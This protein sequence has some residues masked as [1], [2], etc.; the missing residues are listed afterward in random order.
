MHIFLIT[1]SFI[2]DVVQYLLDNAHAN[3]LIFL[4][5]FPVGPRRGRP[6]S[7]PCTI[8]P[9]RRLRT[10]PRP[11]VLIPQAAG[12]PPPPRPRPFFRGPAGLHLRLLLHLPAAAGRV[13]PPPAAG[14]PHSAPA[15]DVLVPRGRLSSFGPCRGRPRT[16]P[17]WLVVRIFPRCGRPPGRYD[18]PA[19]AG[20]TSGR[21]DSSKM[22]RPRTDFKIVLRLLSM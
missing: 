20:L 16:N 14:R 9:P 18:P 5:P 11:A 12:K 3:Y 8:P 19:A 10:P 2:L 6:Y 1:N 4:F 21:Y 7:R 15:A 13:R 22:G 17:P